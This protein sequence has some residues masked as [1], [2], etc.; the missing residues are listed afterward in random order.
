VSITARTA[1]GILEA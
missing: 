1:I